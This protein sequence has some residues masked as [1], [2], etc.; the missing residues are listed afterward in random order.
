MNNIL[1]I[2]DDIKLQKYITEYLSAY[3]YNLFNSIRNSTLL[4]ELR[5][6]FFVTN[7]LLV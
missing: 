3:D 4:G 2:E 6:I 7:I 1:L 5:T